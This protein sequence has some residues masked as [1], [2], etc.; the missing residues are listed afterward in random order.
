MIFWKDEWF[1]SG[2]GATT[3]ERPP[4]LP[5]PPMGTHR[6]PVS[7]KIC[8]PIFLTISKLSQFVLNFYLLKNW[9]NINRDLCSGN[10]IW[11]KFLSVKE[12]VMF[13]FWKLVSSVRENREISQSTSHSHSRYVQWIFTLLTNPIYNQF[14]KISHTFQFPFPFQIYA[15]LGPKENTPSKSSFWLL[16]LLF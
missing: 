8:S 13:V 4:S 3:M 5:F 14:M 11:F 16:F 6:T 10:W 15:D 7:P 2:F 9:M 12:N 1:G